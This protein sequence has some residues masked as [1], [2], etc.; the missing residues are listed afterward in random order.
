[1]ALAPGIIL[2]P[3]ELVVPLSRALTI[4][5]VM[6]LVTLADV[7]ALIG[8]SPKETWAMDIRPHVEAELAKAG[9][10]SDRAADGADV[11]KD[12]IPPSGDDLTRRKP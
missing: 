8:H 5:T 2:C 1:M 7:Q 11:G 9:A 6:D 4:P 10:S 3:P 12:R